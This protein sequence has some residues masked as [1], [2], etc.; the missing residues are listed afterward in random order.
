MEITKYVIEKEREKRSKEDKINRKNELK[1]E[2]STIKDNITAM[3]NKIELM[4]DKIN[5]V[6]SILREY[7]TN[8][9]KEGTDIRFI[10]L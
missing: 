2:W 9:L 5:F 3:E 8:L 10:K 7:Y 4:K 1:A 6:K